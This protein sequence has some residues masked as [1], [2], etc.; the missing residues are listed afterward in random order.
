MHFHLFNQPISLPIL[1][2]L[3]TEL[4][5]Q[6]FLS[7]ALIDQRYPSYYMEP[8]PG[9]C[10]PC[11]RQKNRTTTFSV[12]LSLSS[13]IVDRWPV[14]SPR[15]F[16]IGLIRRSPLACL[17][18]AGPWETSPIYNHYCSLKSQ[19]QGTHSVPTVLVAYLWL[20]LAV[21]LLSR[22]FIICSAISF[23][24]SLRGSFLGNWTSRH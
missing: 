8:S 10:I 21:Y 14:G 1:F 13:W 6:S 16:F 3:G 11:S 4:R 19:N 2:V 15:W 12:S 22:Y 7:F 17:V 5:H 24:F 20:G 9:D 23:I 18:A